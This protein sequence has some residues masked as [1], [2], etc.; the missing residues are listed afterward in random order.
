MR[1]TVLDNLSVGRPE[2]VPSSAELA[3]GDILDTGFVTEVFTTCEIVFHLAARV[4][5]RSSFEYAVDDAQTN[6]AGTASV[7][8]AAEKSRSIR[9]LIVASSMAVYADAPYGHCVDEE[10]STA[11]VSPYGVSKLAVERLTHLMCS[12]AQIDSVVV[13]LFNTYGPRQALSPYVGVVTIF[14]DKLLRGE[15]PVIFG[16]GEQCR[17]FVH[18]RDVARGCLAVMDFGP[19]GATFNIGSGTPRTVNQ[20]LAA[21]NGCMGTSLE[22]RYANAVPGELCY[23]VADI[24]KA[25]R[26]L[27]YEPA[28]DFELTLQALTDEVR[29]SHQL[30]L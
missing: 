27:G 11:P 7:L 2:N 12:R 20:L 17:D 1:V 3:V 19:S 14:I 4:A 22:A 25:S 26:L 24:T 21:L 5:I 28:E 23:S 16:D 8:T 10:Y 6:V 30:S 9:K 29:R 18:A 15:T 13:R